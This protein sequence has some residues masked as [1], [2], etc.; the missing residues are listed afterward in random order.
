MLDFGINPQPQAVGG[1]MG[2]VSGSTLQESLAP[3]PK[4]RNPHC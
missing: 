2:G 3:K 1:R 4:S